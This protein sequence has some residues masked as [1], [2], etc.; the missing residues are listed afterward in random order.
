MVI[1]SFSVG[2]GIGPDTRAPVLVTTSTIFA[3]EELYQL[4][5]ETLQSDS[6]FFFDCHIIASL[7]HFL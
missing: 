4:I 3:A 7:K 2:S 6:D 1:T 5:I